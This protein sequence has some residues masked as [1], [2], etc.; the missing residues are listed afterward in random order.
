MVICLERDA[1]LHMAQLIPLPPAS[2]KSRLVLPFRYRLN[3]VVP[4]KGPLNGCVCAYNISGTAKAGNLK[5]CIRV[6]HA[7][8]HMWQSVTTLSWLSGR[9]QG[10][11]SNFYIVDLE[12]FATASRR[13]TGV[14]NKLVD[15]QLVDY[16][17]DDRARRGWMREF[18]IHCSTVIL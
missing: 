4:D 18:I 1:D 11:V 13:C 15:G 12:N 7:K 6:E 8:W 14:I 16:T 5:F 9:G 2:V 3:W 10:H 17:Y